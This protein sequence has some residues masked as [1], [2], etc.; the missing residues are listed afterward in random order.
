MLHFLRC[1][2]DMFSNTFS[3]NLTV[4]DLAFALRTTF[5][6]TRKTCRSSRVSPKH[7][8]CRYEW[9]VPAVLVKWRR[10][11]ES[12]VRQDTFSQQDV[13]R[14]TLE[15]AYHDIVTE[16]WISDWISLV[17]F[18]GFDGRL[19][20]RQ[21]LRCKRFCVYTC[22]MLLLA[23]LLPTNEV[24]RVK[25]LSDGC[26]Q[27]ND[28]KP[29]AL[30]YHYA[31]KQMMLCDVVIRSFLQRPQGFSFISWLSLPSD[32]CGLSSASLAGGKCG[33]LLC[34]RIRAFDPAEVR[35]ILN[36]PG[37]HWLNSGS[38]PAGWFP[39][40]RLLWTSPSFLL[41]RV[42]A[43]RRWTT[44]VKQ[45]MET[46]LEQSA[47]ESVRQNGCLCYCCR[48]II[49][50]N[51]TSGFPYYGNCEKEVADEGVGGCC[52]ERRSF[53]GAPSSLAMLQDSAVEA[54][55]YITVLRIF[56]RCGS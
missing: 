44:I 40:Q 16:Y 29:A 37:Q 9:S 36:K 28:D 2:N 19:S 49:S 45:D 3:N 53:V 30:V 7:L 38:S 14:Q 50:P 55:A 5:G 11:Y 52:L 48:H 20:T 39:C 56:W 12:P 17:H 35:V 43:S 41:S 34:S 47:N 15:K 25:L 42:C 33:P 27:M 22:L 51:R 46:L 13:G 26:F 23:S 10:Q 21:K 32:F 31:I 8:G 4:Q 1:V 18:S 24:T 54:L 6:L